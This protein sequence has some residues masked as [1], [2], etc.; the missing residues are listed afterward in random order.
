MRNNFFTLKIHRH[1]SFL[2]P[3]FTIAVTALLIQPAFAEEALPPLKQLALNKVAVIESDISELANAL[4]QNAELALTE[5]KSSKKLA[6]YLATQGFRVQEGVADMPTAFVAEWG[7]GKPIIGVVAEFDALPGLGNAVQPKKIPRTD[8]YP[9]GHG[10][11]HN[12]FGAGSV[13]AA[14]A[15]KHVMEAHA[16][17]GTIRLYGAPAEET[18]V[19]K[20]YM[21]KAGLFDDLDAALDWHPSI[22]NT[23]KNHPGQAMNNF[24]VE[25]FGKPA[26]GAYDPWNGRSA[27]DALEHANFGINLMREHIEPT[28]R[29]HYVIENGGKVPNVVPDYARGWYYVRDNNREQVE[30]HYKWILD[31]VKGAALATGTESKV[32]LNTGVHAMLLNRP[33]QDAAYK[34]YQMV[35]LPTYSKDEQAFAKQL[36]K[37]FGKEELGISNELEALPDSIEPSKGGSTDVA[38]ISWI[39]PTVS[40]QVAMAGKGIPWHSWAVAASAGLPGASKAAH[41]AAKILAFTAIDLFTDASLLNAA[42]SEFMESS[43][44]KKYQSPIPKDQRPTIPQ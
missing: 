28:A 33:L 1:G 18:L 14:V 39:A 42:R 17:K 40:I 43:G 21:A 35:E 16:L 8:G 19:G 7:A 34:N 26:H 44:G 12:I 5:K 41:T 9:N 27:L 2:V 30:A 6:E 24:T 37:Q 31:I 22:R 13:G 25:F 29:I 36:Q 32:T 15:I 4:W 11:G 3:L 20:V 38:E 10:C 23:V